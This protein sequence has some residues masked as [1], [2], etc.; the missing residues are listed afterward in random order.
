MTATVVDRAGEQLGDFLP[1]LGGAL[2]LLV[3]GLLIAAVLGRLVRGALTR[4]GLDRLAERLGAADT[5]SR[6]GLGGS[7]SRLA[8]AAVRLSVSVIAV[9]GAL[10]LLG[11]EF[12]SDSLNEGIL[13]IPRLISALF[14]VLLGLVLG[15]LARA[16]VERTA[17]QM[18]FPVALG[19]VVQAV[20]LVIAVLCAAVQLGIAIGTLT[21]LVEI[22][23]AAVA[24]TVALAFGLGG[25][26][27]GRAL[28]ATRYARA[29]FAVGQTIRLG[30]LRGT[31]RQIDS[32]ATT[33]STGT[34]TIRIPNNLLVER[35]VI[36]E[37]GDEPM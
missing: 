6:A 11:L 3:A 32:V 25:R 18:D 7:V 28:T 34:E 13:Y 4:L 17:A 1:R 10:S 12:L 29:D 21:T 31:I 35:V 20:I 9:F 23:L 37:E 8:G 27:I 16:W 30:E 33:L 2:V 14:L 5:L 24:A 36:V 22:I 15:A 26:E 19:P